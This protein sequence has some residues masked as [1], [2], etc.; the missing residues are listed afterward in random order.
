VIH[1]LLPKILGAFGILLFLSPAAAGLQPRPSNVNENFSTQALPQQNLRQDPQAPG[2][3]APTPEQVSTIQVVELEGNRLLIQADQPIATYTSGWDRTTAAYQIRIAGAR[4]GNGV[5]QPQLDSSSALLRIRLSQEENDTVVIRVYPAP[6]VQIGTTSQPDRQSLLLSLEGRPQRRFISPSESAS[7]QSSSG[8]LP[9]VS[10][11]RVTI[12]ID[13]GHGGHD[14]GAVG[15]DGL[16]EKGIVLDVALQVASLLEQQ[17][18][19]VLLTRQNDVE[20]DLEPRVQQANQ[21]RADVFVS[22]HANSIDMSHP[23]INGVETYYYSSS[24]QTLAQVVQASL[25]EE[26][27]MR[28]IGVKFARFYVLR[29]TAMPSALVEIGFVTGRDDAARLSDPNFRKVIAE[30]IARGILQYVQQRFQPG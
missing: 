19:R 13:P 29:N 28:S 18:A 10:S 24:G 23:N 25:T 14:P 3:V 11:T 16:Q 15:I 26:T 6:G 12:A 27:Q 2:P 5:A 22:I 17:G 30:G 4:L 20:I 7:R 9:D 21:A 8:A 1:W